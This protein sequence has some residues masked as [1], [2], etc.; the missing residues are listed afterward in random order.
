[1][2]GTYGSQPATMMA[3]SPFFYYNPDTTKDTKQQGH[4][5][6]QPQCSQYTQQQEQF[7]ENV[8]VFN[9]SFLQQQGPTSS[10]SQIQFPLKHAYV[11]QPLLTPVASP[12]FPYH[13][14]AVLYQQD[15]PYLY[16]I[17]TDCSDIRLAP[18]TP[19]LSSSGSAINS[20]PSTCEHLLTPVT[21]SPYMGATEAVKEGHE[22]EVFNEILAAGEWTAA[23]PPLTPV[24]IQTPTFSVSRAPQNLSHGSYLLSA[25]ACPSLSPSPSP[26]PH[27]TNTNT[28]AFCDPRN[29]SVDSSASLQFPCLPTLCSGDDEEHKLILRGEAFAEPQEQAVVPTIEFPFS[30]LPTF[31]PLFE[32]DREDEFS[33]LIPF[34]STENAHFLGNKRQRTQLSSVS[35]EDDTVLSED[36][37]SDFDDEFVTLGLPTLPE[38]ELSATMYTTKTNKKRPARRSKSSKASVDPDFDFTAASADGNEAEAA[39]ADHG[40]PLSE[41]GSENAVST[42]SEQGAQPTQTPSSRRGRKQSLTEDPSKTFVC[43]ICNRRFRRQEHLK[44]H[45]RSLHTHDKPFECGD[46]GKKFSR[47]DNLSQHQR[48]HG[49]GAV[50]MGVLD[51]EECDIDLGVDGSYDSGDTDRMGANLYDV[52][53]YVNTE[54]SESESDGQAGQAHASSSGMEGTLKKRKREE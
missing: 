24:Y 33:S 15:S 39:M 20:P 31:E 25:T 13:K 17:D 54:S 41:A 53:S 22:E 52:A 47:S 7:Q 21:G 44:R 6:A 14:A 26:I 48:T 40:S 11:S 23:S 45:Y 46:C 50:V 10:E 51:A 32:L 49:V 37:F 9:S 19:P 35:T 38:G 3:Q 28:A 5:T 12:H 4:F 27:V 29:L 1:M 43:D 18:A 34:P 2:Q 42:T 8:P 36:S 16:P 30:G